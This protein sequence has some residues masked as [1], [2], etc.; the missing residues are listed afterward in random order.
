MWTIVAASIILVAATTP[1]NGQVA[2]RPTV[3]TSTVCGHCCHE[4]TFCEATSE[5]ATLARA[6]GGLSAGYVI[7]SGTAMTCYL[8]DRDQPGAVDGGLCIPS[9]GVP[10]ITSFC[11]DLSGTPDT[12]VVPTIY[13][14][15]KHEAPELPFINALA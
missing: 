5:A 15:G 4:G 13:E 2:Y 12:R 7:P 8:R 9:N 1:A 10:D 14:A 11:S 3:P 6:A